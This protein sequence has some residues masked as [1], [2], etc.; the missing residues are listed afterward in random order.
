MMATPA[1]MVSGRPGKFLESSAAVWRAVWRAVGRRSGG[2][3]AAVGRLFV[4]ILIL[5]HKNF[6][7]MP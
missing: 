3:S 5:Y 1:Y 6:S 7:L 2:R 4:R